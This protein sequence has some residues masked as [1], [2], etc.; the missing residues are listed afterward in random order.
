VPRARFVKAPRGVRFA[1]FPGRLRMK[2]AF[3]VAAQYRNVESTTARRIEMGP[4]AGLPEEHVVRRRMGPRADRRQAARAHDPREAGAA[5]QGR[6][7][8]RGGAGQPMLPPRREALERPHGGRRHPLHVPRAQVRPERQV[9]PDPRPGQ[10]P[11]GTRREQLPGRRAAAPRVDLD[12]R[13]G[14]GRSIED[15]RHPVP[16]R[17][18]RG[19]ACRTTCTTTR[20]IC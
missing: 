17:I 7:R 18:R 15:H 16:A 5:L 3:F 10:H 1:E 9:H 14:E 6:E 11:E 12:G 8:A 19:A 13:S 20:T 4:N 2:S